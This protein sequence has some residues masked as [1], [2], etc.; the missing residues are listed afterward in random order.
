MKLKNYLIVVR[1]IEKARQF[2]HDLFGLEMLTDNDGNNLLF[3]RFAGKAAGRVDVCKANH[4]SY[5][6]AM[7]PEFVQE[8]QARVYAINVWD[9]LHTQD[10]TMTNMSSQELYPGERLICTGQMEPEEQEEFKNCPWMKNVGIAT[11]HMVVRVFDG[12]RKYKVY[13]L[14]AQDES[15]KITAVYGPFNSYLAENS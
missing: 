9:R 2:Y 4:H 1:D 15:M 5:K 13:F 12:G 10:N 8:V 11:G 14:T 6:D 7:I 3:E